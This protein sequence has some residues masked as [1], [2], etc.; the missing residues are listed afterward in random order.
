MKTVL[1]ATWLTTAIETLYSWVWS[2]VLVG[3][4]LLT[5][6]YFSIRTRASKSNGGG[7][8]H[9]IARAH[10][11][12]QRHRECLERGDS[13]FLRLIRVEEQTAHLS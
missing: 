13:R 5:A 3:L 8:S 7:D 4:C 11:A 9:D 2:P 10:S 1:V 12:R 6:F